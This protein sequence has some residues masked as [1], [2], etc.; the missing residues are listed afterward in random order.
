MIMYDCCDLNAPLRLPNFS[1]L[2]SQLPTAK[3]GFSSYL[4]LSLPLILSSKLNA[5]IR[6]A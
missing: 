1:L 4:S 3:F 5:P 2:A 6:P